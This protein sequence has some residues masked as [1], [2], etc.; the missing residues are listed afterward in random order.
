MLNKL[1]TFLRQYEMV[2]PGDR[3]ICA[4]SGGADSVALLWGMYLLREKLQ[5][6]VEAAHYNHCLRGA[7]SQAD[8]DFV[9]AFCDRYDIPLHLGR[10]VV[11]PGK[12]GLEAAARDARYGFLRQ[13]PGVIA[14]AH[15]ADDNGETVL[16]HMIRGTGLKGLGGIT[17]VGERLIR[18][19]LSV[20]REDVLAFLDEYSLSFVQDSTNDTDAFL[21]NRLR[22]HVIP[23][24]K[25]ENPKLAATLSAM[26]LR[27]RED[28]AFLQQLAVAGKTRQIAELRALPTPVRSRVLAMLLE[29][30]EVC[31]PS[32]EHI[33]M[34]QN[35]IDSDRP[36][37]KADFPGNI[38]VG[39]NYGVLE[40]RTQSEDYC[41]PLQL[42][43]AVTL[44]E[45]GLQV[46]CAQ[47]TENGVQ[48]V[49]DM[50]VRSRIS[51]DE[52]RLPGGRKSLK[53]LFID[54]KIPAAQRHT[55]PVVADDLGVL[56]VYGFGPNLDRVTSDSRGVEIRF[57]G[58]EK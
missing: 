5:I 50:V 28:E 18:P 41:F 15:T 55:V 54:R 22:H 29:E 17:P 24:L 23:Q 30:F 31:E 27:L 1:L 44:T 25:S 6:T 57:E 58:L 32:A 43:G 3:V 37:A 4:V 35:V 33:A 46:T 38:T 36:S 51:G 39:R 47:S 45:L 48:P 53:K 14:T 7:E 20:T 26:A 2:Q 16:M 56:W 34:L 10:G 52:I 13:L 21:R 19:M 12:K 49:G 42:D 9:K 8:E 40:K 11:V